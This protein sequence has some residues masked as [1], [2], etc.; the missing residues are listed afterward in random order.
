MKARRFTISLF[1]FVA[2]VLWVGVGCFHGED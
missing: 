1:V 2:I